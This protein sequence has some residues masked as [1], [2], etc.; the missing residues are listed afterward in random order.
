MR[1]HSLRLIRKIK[2]IAKREGPALFIFSA[3]LAGSFV[4]YSMASEVSG[5]NN[6]AFSWLV[7]AGSITS[8]PRV[9][10]KMKNN[11]EPY[12]IQF[13]RGFGEGFLPMASSMPSVIA[14]IKDGLSKI[15]RK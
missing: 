15:A 9:F 1:P 7:I 4:F 11:H 6:S 3:V 14:H 13:A 10:S 8:L 2:Q 5:N 12:V